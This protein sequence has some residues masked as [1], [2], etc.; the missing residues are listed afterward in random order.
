MTDELL[1]R[2]YSSDWERKTPLRT[3]RVKPGLFWYSGFG[4]GQYFSSDGFMY[5]GSRSECQQLADRDGLKMETV[6]SLEGYSAVYLG[7]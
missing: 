3:I 4:Y 7:D 5:D 1:K 6:D 2:P